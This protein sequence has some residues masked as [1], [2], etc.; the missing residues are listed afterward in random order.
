MVFKKDT[1][2][3]LGLMLQK[4][5][6]ISEDVSHRIKTDWLKWRQTSGVLC[7][8]SVSLKLKDKFYMT[9]IRPTLL[10]RAEYWP[11]KR[12]YLATKRS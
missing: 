11:T 4:D 7:D 1:F 6:G 3:Y 12:T 10:Y 8:P 2:R 9:V 5:G